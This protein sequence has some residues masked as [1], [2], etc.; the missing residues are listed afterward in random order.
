MLRKKRIFLRKLLGLLVIPLIVIVVL[1]YFLAYLPAMRIKAKGMEVMAEAQLLK[2][3]VKQNDIDLISKRLNTISK[4]YDAFEKESKSV[5]WATFIPYVRDFKNGVEAGD[6]MIHAGIESVKAIEPYA[7]LIGFKKGEGGNFYD[8]SSEERLQTAVLTLDKMLQKIDVVSKD[9]DEAEKRIETIDPNRY[10]E[11]FGNRE[12]RSQLIAAKDQFK[13][14]ASLFVDAKP[15][16]KNLPE[17]LGSDGEKTYLILFQNTAERRATGGFLTFYAIF[18]INKG[19]ITIDRSSDIYDIDDNIGSHPSAPE[20]IL[21]YHKGVNRFYIRDSNLSP[22]FV[23]SVDLFESLYS[24]AGNKVKYDGIIAMDSKVLVDMLKIFGDTQAGGVTFS[25]EKDERCDCPQVIYTL[26][27]I[28]DRPVNY[29]K[30]NRKGIVGELM[31]QLFYKAIGFSPSKYWGRLAETMFQNLDE[32]HIL[33]YFTEK[34]IQKSIENLNWA[35]RIKD[36]KGDYLHINQV[37]FAGAKSNLFIDEK[38][39]SETTFGNSITRKVT[40][41]YRNPYRHSDC[42]LERG[43]LCLNATLRNWVRVYIPKGSKLVKFDGSQTKVLTYEELD[44]TVFE[45]FMTVQPQGKAEITV[46]YTLPAD[47]KKDGYKLLMQK[48]PGNQKQTLEVKVDGKK[49]FDGKFN[50]DKEIK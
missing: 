47:I 39:V 2:A 49:R 12:V 8:K 5:Y 28:V 25:A 29:V 35:G 31:Y 38:I 40:V 41:E 37:N 19:K 46:E 45:G 18:N 16:L 7:D 21:A 22:D 23:E 27:D 30:T 32:K 9:I 13:G 11:K 43:G 14:L 20:K 48:Q 42:N 4:K 36:Y 24:K 10:P 26:F 17:I 34:D 1:G 50:T 44:K 15:F 3:D 33:L 6:Y